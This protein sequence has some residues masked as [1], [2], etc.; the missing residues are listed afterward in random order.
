LHARQES[1]RRSKSGG[2]GST[3]G[4]CC[5]PAYRGVAWS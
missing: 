4:F 5:G 3:Q 2:V 1:N